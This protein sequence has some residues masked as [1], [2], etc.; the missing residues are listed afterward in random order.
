MLPQFVKLNHEPITISKSPSSSPGFV[1]L[2]FVC[3]MP[4]EKVNQTSSDPNGG[5]F[6]ADLPTLVEVHNKS[7]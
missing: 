4:M 5:E 6:D 2:G 3:V 1:L 7:P